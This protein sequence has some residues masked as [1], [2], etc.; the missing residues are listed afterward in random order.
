MLVF[1]VSNRKYAVIINTLFALTIGFYSYSCR[2][3]DNLF[4]SSISVTYT[5]VCVAVT[6]SAIVLA[7][8][9]TTGLSWQSLPNPVK[10]YVSL[11]AISPAVFSCY[12]LMTMAAYG[13]TVKALWHIR[14]LTMLPLAI[15]DC[16]RNETVYS[17]Q[18]LKNTSGFEES[19]VTGVKR[20]VGDVI[21][22][23]NEVNGTQQQ[24]KTALELGFNWLENKGLGCRQVMTRPFE[25]CLNASETAK[26]D[27]REN[28]G[29]GP[30]CDLV[31]ISESVCKNLIVLSKKSCQE[32]GPERIAEMLKG[33]RTSLG[34]LVSGAIT[35]R[36]G[37]LLELHSTSEV[38]HELELV[39]NSIVK[40][41]KS[42]SDTFRFIYHIVVEYLL[43][44]TPIGLIV[45]GPVWYL[46]QYIW[47]SYRFD[48]NYITR[49]QCDELVSHGLITDFPSDQSQVQIVPAWMPTFNEMIQILHDIFLSIDQWIV[50]VVLV[51]D[52]YY[53]NWVN[54]LHHRWI[55]LFDSYENQLFDITQ[56]PKRIGVGWIGEMIA[57]QLGKIQ[58]AIGLCRLLE[59]GR[60]APPLNYSYNIFVLAMAQRVL[61]TL[62]RTKFRFLQSY[63]CARFY[64]RRHYMRI[65]YLKSKILLDAVT[66]QK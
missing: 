46:F 8:G 57:Q 44:Y 27:C 56:Q 17:V 66:K 1:A 6:T 47:G 11:V 32:L 19:H 37:I 50:A 33:F 2:I 48:N 21:T 16:L 18:L 26:K 29:A 51:I 42:G 61:Y 9:F 39:W 45:F 4:C 24:F 62:I 7:T 5:P 14:Q 55:T 36:V 52:Y 60:P 59:C 65:R 35:M 41:L 30:L 58:E 3:G 34:K 20:G 22:T 43:N 12:T 49:D 25:M 63:I 53:T 64:R 54:E 23:F 40:T 15:V 31:D 28:K 10:T 13:E 38:E